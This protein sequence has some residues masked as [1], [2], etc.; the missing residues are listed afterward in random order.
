[1]KEESKMVFSDFHFY[2]EVLGIQ[3]AAYVLLPDE[4]TLMRSRT[5]VPVLY[6]LHGLSDD[7]TMWLRQTR[8]ESYAAKRRLAVV[9]PAAN[10][11]FYMDMVHG[12]QYDTFIAE[13]LPRVIERYF[14]VG[15][16]RSQ[17]FAAGLSMGGYGAIKLGLSRPNRYAAIASL[18][19]ALGIENVYD[20]GKS[21]SFLHEMDGI[22]GG[23]EQLLTG[24]GS[25]SRLAQRMS[26]TPERAPKIY[27]A[28]GTEDFLLEQNERFVQ[29]FGQ[30][31]P[32]EYHTEPGAHTWE[33]WDRNIGRAINW[34]PL[35]EEA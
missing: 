6:L 10:R 29:H 14:P 5:A 13:E 2:S 24:P 12:A 32:I 11:S 4:E 28:C 15:H 9:M 16:K 23:R 30:A 34:L 8:V 1:M 33:F 21:A 31:L 25:L 27:I 7:H 19:G 20:E 18:S 35:E 17:R 26:R 3:T 22:Y